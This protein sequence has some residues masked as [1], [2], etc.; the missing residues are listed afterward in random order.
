MNNKENVAAKCTG[1]DSINRQMHKP[2][3]VYCVRGILI[4]R[5]QFVTMYVLS[6]QLLARYSYVYL[7]L[8]MFEIKST[9]FHA[10][11][12]T[13]KFCLGDR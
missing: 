7:H 5:L 1:T 11:A 2:N 10:I 8:Y 6:L 3:I 12:L 13:Y 9:P 4:C